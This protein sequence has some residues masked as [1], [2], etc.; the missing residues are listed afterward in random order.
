ML[1]YRA[2]FDENF[3]LSKRQLGVLLLVAG[4]VTFAAILSIDIIDAG[5]EGGIGPAQRIAL[6]L[7]V[8]LALVGLTLIPLGDDPA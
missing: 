6:S 8:A 2:M 1:Y 5:R 4:A 3:T 7:A